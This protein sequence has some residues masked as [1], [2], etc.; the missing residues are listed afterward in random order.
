MGGKLNR[1]RRRGLSAALVAVSV[2][3][4]FIVV[5]AGVSGASTRPASGSA[6]TVSSFAVSPAALPSTGGTATLSADVTNASDC[7]FSSKKPVAGLPVSVPCSNGAVSTGITLAASTGN[8]AAIYTFVVKVTGSK[9]VKAKTSLTVDPSYCSDIAPGA[10]LKNCDLSD[11]DLSNAELLGADLYKSNL[12]GATLLDA[13]LS[14]TNLTLATLAGI[15]AAGATFVDAT[16]SD[17]KLPDA[18]LG[19]ADMTGA[20]VTDSHLTDADLTGADLQDVD[21]D[22]AS[23]QGANFTQAD[24]DGASMAAVNLT[25][26]VWDDTTCPDGSN[27]NN[28]GDTCANNL[29]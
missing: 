6:T 21:F 2:L 27:S 24:L 25:G 3:S 23:L 26:A 1:A 8:R 20:R 17:A 11:A 15:D 4:V 13:D 16:L 7:T 28:R 5:D 22:G 18:E 9:T 12:T 19:G 29:G 14:D 10:D